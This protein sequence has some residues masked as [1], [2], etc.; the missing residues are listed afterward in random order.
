MALAAA[1]E[2]EVKKAAEERMKS[3][4]KPS[5]NFTEGTPGQSRDKL[6]SLV[7]LSGR[8]L[9]RATAVVEAANTIPS[10]RYFITQFQ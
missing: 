4:K 6:G 7:G 9:E 5:V 2:P 3:G 8:S 1:L 10:S